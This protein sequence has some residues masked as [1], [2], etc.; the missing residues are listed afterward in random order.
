MKL[1]KDIYILVEWTKP[2]CKELWD[3]LWE[4]G[5]KHFRHD[6]QNF[7]IFYVLNSENVFNNKVLFRVRESNN[8]FSCTFYNNLKDTEYYDLEDFK[9]LLKGNTNFIFP[10]N[11]NIVAKGKDEIKEVWNFLNNNKISHEMYSFDTYSKFEDY[12]ILKDYDKEL[13]FSNSLCLTEPRLN[14]YSVS[15]HSDEF[16]NYTLDEF[17]KLFYKF[18]VNNDNKIVIKNFNDQTTWNFILTII[19]KYIKFDFSAFESYFNNKRYLSIKNLQLRY[20]GMSNG[21]LLEDS[22]YKIYEFDARKDLNDI[23]VFI[24]YYFY[25]LEYR[26]TRIF[27]LKSDNDVYYD[28]I[29][30]KIIID[31]KKIHS[32]FFE[33]LVEMQKKLGDLKL[34]EIKFDNN[35]T[36]SMNDVEEM[37]ANMNLNK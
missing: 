9:S 35:A 25:T 24:K 21:D 3:L 16:T 7:D 20:G 34:S 14:V 10:T 15:R 33:Y 26:K 12:F 32:Q 29:N 30:S 19:Q 5:F 8:N 31:D 4:N 18:N 13:Y 1:D 27:N 28:E 2:K 22:K 11:V 36:F 6:K 37:V 17:I 23:I